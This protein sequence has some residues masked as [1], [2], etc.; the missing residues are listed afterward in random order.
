MREVV[1][2]RTTGFLDY[3]AARDRPEVV[4]AVLAADTPSGEMPLLVRDP[5]AA[6]PPSM[7]SRPPLRDALA[8]VAVAACEMLKRRIEKWGQK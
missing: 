7:P 4:A 8:D 2:A 5:P 6:T 1:G 3:G